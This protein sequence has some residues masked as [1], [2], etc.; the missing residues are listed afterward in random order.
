MPELVLANGQAKARVIWVGKCFLPTFPSAALSCSRQGHGTA[1]GLVRWWPQWKKGKHAGLFWDGDFIKKKKNSKCISVRN[2]WLRFNCMSGKL[3]FTLFGHFYTDD[4]VW[5]FSTSVSLI[6][7]HFVPAKL[8]EDRG[9][10]GNEKD[11]NWATAASF[12]QWK[13]Q[14]H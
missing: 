7:Q 6:C 4:W 1:A 13:L 10:I 8:R 11:E 2:L 14:R 3:F 9:P 5:S 12:L